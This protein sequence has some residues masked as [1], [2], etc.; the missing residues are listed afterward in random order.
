MTLILNSAILITEAQTM[1]FTDRILVDGE[2]GIFFALP[3]ECRTLGRRGDKLLL[4]AKRDRKVYEGT[5]SIEFVKGLGELAAH[6]LIEN[7]E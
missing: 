7:T 5:A 6:L 2:S 3:S 1:D 4:E